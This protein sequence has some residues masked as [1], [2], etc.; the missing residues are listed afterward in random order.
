MKTSINLKEIEAKYTKSNYRFNQEKN[1][2]L[3]PQIVD[4]VSEKKWINIRPEYQ[5]RLV[6][7]N[8]KKSLYL[9]SLLMNL[10]T[11]PIFLFECDYNRYEVMDG[12]Q[13][14]NTICEFYN[15][16]FKL[17]GLEKWSEINNL[18]YKECPPI[19][20]SGFDRR[21]INATVLLFESGMYQDDSFK[22][23]MRKMVFERLNTGGINLNAQ[24]IR[25]CIYASKFCDMLTELSGYRLFDE[26]WEIPPY[27]DNIRKDII[28]KELSNNSRFKRMQD[29]EIV[30]RFFAFKDEKYISGA[31]KKILDQCMERNKNLNDKDIELL[32]NRFKNVIQL[33]HEIFGEDTFKIKEAKRKVLSI[34]LYDGV[35]VSIDKLFDRKEEIINKKHKIKKALMSKLSNESFY[36]IILGTNTAQSLKDRLNAVEKV[37]LNNL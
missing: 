25:H 20:K 27:E 11:P 24:E 23:E 2:F 19:I 15:N 7:D 17:K 8:K 36:K 4:F 28:T 37:I 6:W 5:R 10:P 30:L 32:K 26:I 1:D 35:M 16:N 34:T 13:R 3:L 12:Q 9:E 29:C 21:R 14:L 22:K 18:T 31:V 33:A